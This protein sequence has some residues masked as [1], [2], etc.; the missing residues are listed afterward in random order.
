MSYAMPNTF[1]KSLNISC[2]FHWNMSS[3]GAVP[4][5]N[6]LYLYLPNWHANVVRYD[7]F[8]SGLRL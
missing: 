6:L 2:I 7:D 8:P 5:G 3:A 1:G 4:N